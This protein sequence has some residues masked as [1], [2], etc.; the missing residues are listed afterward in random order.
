MSRKG[1]NLS[2][3]DISKETEM[4]APSSRA[5]HVEP[6]PPPRVRL[7]SSLGTPRSL[8]RPKKR[9]PLAFEEDYLE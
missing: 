3:I 6:V 1:R 5:R 9:L 4:P 8:E 2:R 7:P